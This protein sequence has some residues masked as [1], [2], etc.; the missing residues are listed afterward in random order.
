MASKMVKVRCLG[1]GEPEHWFLSR[2]KCRVRMCDRCKKKLA[3][4]PAE[5]FFT[6]HFPKQGEK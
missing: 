6:S 2:D 4:I 1:P 3:F 5:R